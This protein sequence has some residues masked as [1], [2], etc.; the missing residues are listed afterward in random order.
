MDNG[1]TIKL[2]NINNI[3]LIITIN[4][5]FFL[6]AFVPDQYIKSNNL[7]ECRNAI[8]RLQNAAESAGSYITNT[9]PLFMINVIC[10]GM[11]I[12]NNN[13]IIID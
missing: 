2:I 7:N 8:G 4:N 11:I 5:L 3:I 9:I 13:N 12:I 1:I 10:S 6:D